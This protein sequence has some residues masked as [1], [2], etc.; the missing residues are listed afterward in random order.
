[1]ACVAG[2]VVGICSWRV[3][4]VVGENVGDRRKAIVCLCCGYVMDMACLA[5]RT[6]SM[7]C[8]ASVRISRS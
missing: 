2:R 7:L 4:A 1:M 8:E 6:G 5:E 3:E